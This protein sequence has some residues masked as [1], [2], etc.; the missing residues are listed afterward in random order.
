MRCERSREQQ[1]SPTEYESPPSNGAI[2]IGAQGRGIRHAKVEHGQQKK[3]E[4]G[5]PRLPDHHA[6]AD[7]HQQ[8]IANESAKLMTDSNT[9]RQSGCNS[10]VCSAV[11][12][13]EYEER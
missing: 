12:H 13:A 3:Q 2:I 7:R 6:K 5:E 11:R 1:L 8:Q 10:P 9:P 4:R